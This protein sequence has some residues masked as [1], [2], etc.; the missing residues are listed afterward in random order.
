MYKKYTKNDFR[1]NILLE[2]KMTIILYSNNEDLLSCW[3]NIS[4]KLLRPILGVVESDKNELIL[5]VDG[6]PT[7]TY[8]G[9]MTYDSM[10]YFCLSI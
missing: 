4:N 6:Y 9:D 2:E 5:Y 3:N 1:L 7:K 10:L 8:N